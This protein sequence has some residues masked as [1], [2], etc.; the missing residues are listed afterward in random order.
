[1][2]TQNIKLIIQYDGTCYSGWQIQK[3]QKTIQG[4]L[5][6]VI[7]DITLSDNINI[8]GSGR[9]DAGVHAVAQVANFKTKSKMTCIQFTKAINSKISNDITV[10]SSSLVSSDFNSRFSA[11]SREYIY[12]IS[13]VKTPFNYKYNWINKANIKYDVLE[14]CA[15]IILLEKNFFNFCKHSQEVKNYFCDISS[16][17]WNFLNDENKTL[18]FKIKAN[19]FLHHMVRMLVGTMLEVSRGKITLDDFKSIFYD[20]NLKNMVNTAPPNGLFLS[21]IYYED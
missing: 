1:M 13:S 20:S 5:K 21:K 9:T 17:T 8:I 7:E 4:E 2:S 6:K 15:N 14:K 3:D 11:K 12:N 16:S 10:V 19:R 18:Q